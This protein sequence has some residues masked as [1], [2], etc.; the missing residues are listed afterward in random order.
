METENR[1]TAVID[2]EV[3][4]HDDDLLEFGKQISEL[5]LEQDRLMT[6]QKAAAANFKARLNDNEAQR[7]RLSRC[8][9]TRKEMRTGECEVIY[10]FDDGYVRYKE[11]QS[12]QI[13]S[14]RKMTP[15]EHQLSLFGG[16]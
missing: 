14:S 7:K 4:L 15:E 2:Y 13:V 10:D 8:I 12:G 5:D 6:E 9:R 11:I 3:D 1:K 16:E